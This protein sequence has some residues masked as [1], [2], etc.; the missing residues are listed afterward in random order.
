MGRVAC[1][2]RGCLGGRRSSLREERERE[3][4]RVCTSREGEGETASRYWRKTNS[5]G[6]H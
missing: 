6:H 5:T 1:H 3:R 2:L 4:E